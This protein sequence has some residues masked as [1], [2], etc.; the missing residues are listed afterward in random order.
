MVCDCYM[1]LL[2]KDKNKK[3]E[4]RRNRYLYISDE[5]KQKLKEH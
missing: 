2:K 3:R 5:D 4:C 1:R